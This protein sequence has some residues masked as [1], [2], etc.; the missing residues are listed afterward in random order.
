MYESNPLARPDPNFM[1]TSEWVKRHA[2]PEALNNWP[3]AFNRAVF[4]QDFENTNDYLKNVIANQKAL[5]KAPYFANLPIVGK[6]DAAQVCAGLSTHS[7][8]AGDAA[9]GRSRWFL[10]EGGPGASERN[11]KEHGA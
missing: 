8:L 9:H 10:S 4:E 1:P 11:R 5:A 7:A 2:D 3:N 6:L